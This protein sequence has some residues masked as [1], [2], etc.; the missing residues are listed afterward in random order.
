MND[1]RQLADKEKRLS[2]RKKS[3]ACVSLNL[4][5]ERRIWTFFDGVPL[6]VINHASSEFCQNKIKVLRYQRVVDNSDVA[7]TAIL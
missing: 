3:I 7:D 5:D 2:E 6:A 1:F 4:A